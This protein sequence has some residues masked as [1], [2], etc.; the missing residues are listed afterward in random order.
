MESERRSLPIAVKGEDFV[1]TPSREQVTPTAPRGG[2]GQADEPRRGP[3]YRRRW[4]WQDRTEGERY[5]CARYWEE[6]NRAE[7][8]NARAESL[9][10]C[11][12]QVAEQRNELLAK[13]VR[14]EKKLKRAARRAE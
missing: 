4:S 1:P 10:D 8:D 2:E 12:R 5:W 13:V 14:L 3:V 11:L 6:H 9:E 7:S